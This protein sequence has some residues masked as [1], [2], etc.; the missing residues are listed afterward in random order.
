M[1]HYLARDGQFSH[2]ESIP[3]ADRE[4]KCRIF[5]LAHGLFVLKLPQLSGFETVGSAA[6]DAGTPRLWL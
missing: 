5:S 1:G 2:F 6:T 3:A 4:E